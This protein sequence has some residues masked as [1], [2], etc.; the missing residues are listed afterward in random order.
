MGFL[1]IFCHCRRKIDFLLPIL[2]N[3]NLFFF[4]YT[5]VFMNL[6]VMH[7]SNNDNNRKQ[8][9]A[10]LFSA[11]EFHHSLYHLFHLQDLSLS[12]AY[13]LSQTT[14]SSSIILVIFECYL[15]IITI[16]S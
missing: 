4:S 10:L 5:I 11:H 2:G 13:L 8:Y 14:L 6:T 15:H 7:Y 16:R 1:R 12:P 3:L 9:V